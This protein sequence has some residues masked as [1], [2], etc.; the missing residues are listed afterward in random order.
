MKLLRNQYNSVTWSWLVVIC[1]C[2]LSSGC[3]SAMTSDLNDGDVS[4]KLLIAIEGVRYG[5]TENIPVYVDYQYG[6]FSGRVTRESADQWIEIANTREYHTLYLTWVLQSGKTIRET[7]DVVEELRVRKAKV[8]LPGYKRMSTELRIRV[9]G[10]YASVKY[11]RSGYVEDR[12]FEHF[13]FIFSNTGI[14]ADKE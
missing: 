4:V 8:K 5:S 10:I 2:V 1:I 7:V 11:L 3:S 6:N 12:I 13:Y 14:P 9:W